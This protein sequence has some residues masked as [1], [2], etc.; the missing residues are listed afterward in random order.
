ME[1]VITQESQFS[2]SFRRDIYTKAA[3]E[4]F[5]N[6]NESNLFVCLMIEDYVQNINEIN[7]Y[8]ITEKDF[9]EIFSF[10]EECENNAWLSYPYTE[11]FPNG[12]YDNQSEE[13]YI[14]KPALVN[15]FKI[16][17]CLLAAEMCK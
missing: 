15:N 17:V 2:P 11:K 9:P 10:K 16:L 12:Q 6:I 3:N 7:S 14:K 1:T 13:S 5:K 4:L 8:D